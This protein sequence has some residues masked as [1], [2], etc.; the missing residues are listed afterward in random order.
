M[1]LA[2]L[3]VLLGLATTIAVARLAIPPEAQWV[4]KPRTQR[5]MSDGSAILRFRVATAD[6][7][8]ADFALGSEAAH[9]SRSASEWRAFLIETIGTPQNGGV[10]QV[11]CERLP[12]LAMTDS[13]WPLR[14]FYTTLE[15]RQFGPPFRAP[16]T[17][18]L[19]LDRVVWWP[20]TVNTVVFA[21]LWAMLIAGPFL[22]TAARGRHRA[23]CGRCPNCNYDRTGITAEAVCPEC[24]KEP[25]LH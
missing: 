5:N 16:A 12:P 4:F 1:A 3:S 9:Q 21:A 8:V 25:G 24:G 19:A 14:C 15:E 2:V 20:L 11:G 23:R 17:Q 13:G 10:D 7:Y 22:F 18:L 6:F